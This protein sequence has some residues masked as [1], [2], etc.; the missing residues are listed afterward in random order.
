MQIAGNVL[1]DLALSK[2]HLHFRFKQALHF[3]Y[4]YQ[5]QNRYWYPLD[6]QATFYFFMNIIKWLKR[7][8]FNC[9]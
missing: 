2:V 9:F 8:N 5:S 7:R 3:S 1:E 6:L 4:D